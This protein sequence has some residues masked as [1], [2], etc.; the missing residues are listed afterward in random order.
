MI[1]NNIFTKTGDD[2][3]RESVEITNCSDD[4]KLT[5]EPEF[6][7]LDDSTDIF[8]SIRNRY[9][10]RVHSATDPPIKDTSVV[11]Q[12]LFRL[13]SAPETKMDLKDILND[14]LTCVVENVTLDE[15]N[16][17]DC[18][19]SNLGSSSDNNEDYQSRI[20]AEVVLPPFVNKE[21]KRQDAL[22]VGPEK[23]S[24]QD[25]LDISNSDESFEETNDM[26]NEI[27]F[28]SKS[29]S[30]DVITARDR[31]IFSTSPSGMYNGKPKS[32]SLENLYKT[33]EYKEI[34]K[35]ATSIEFCNLNNNYSEMSLYTEGS[36]SVFLSPVKKQF[37]KVDDF[38]RS[39]IVPINTDRRDSVI[40]SDTP[41]HNVIRT[42]SSFELDLGIN[43][44]VVK[45]EAILPMAYPDDIKPLPRMPYI[46]PVKEIQD[47]ISTEE[48]VKDIKKSNEEKL[49]FKSALNRIMGSNK[50]GSN[51][52]R[53]SSSPSLKLNDTDSNIASLN[54]YA[55]V[56]KNMNTIENNESQTAFSRFHI[57]RHSSPKLMKVKQPET[58]SEDVKNSPETISESNSA[59]L[60]GLNR[61]DRTSVIQF[62]ETQS[63]NGLVKSFNEAK[64]VDVNEK[65]LLRSFKQE[66]EVNK[67]EI[68]N[69]LHTIFTCM[70][71]VNVNNQKRSS[72]NSHNENRCSETPKEN[73]YLLDDEIITLDSPNY[74]KQTLQTSGA[75]IFDEVK[76]KNV[77]E[78]AQKSS[79]NLV[80]STPTNTK[81][82]DSEILT[83]E[84][85]DASEVHRQSKPEVCNVKNTKQNSESQESENTPVEHLHLQIVRDKATK[86]ATSMNT[87]T[88]EDST[89]LV[90]VTISKYTEKSEDD[91][92]DNSKV[93]ETTHAETFENN[94]KVI[95]DDTISKCS[96][97]STNPFLS[98]NDLSSQSTK[99]ATEAPFDVSYHLKINTV[100]DLVCQD[101]PRVAISKPSHQII[102]TTP[103]VQ[104]IRNFL[105]IQIINGN[106]F[107][108]MDRT[109]SPII[110]SPVLIQPIFF[111]PN[112]TVLDLD[113]KPENNKA[114]IYYDDIAQVKSSE[115]TSPKV[116]DLPK[117][118]ERQTK[119]QYQKNVKGK[120]LPFLSWKA[121]DSNESP[122]PGPKSPPSRISPR[123]LDSPKQ[124]V[125]KLTKTPEFLI[126]NHYYQPMEKVPFVIN[127]TQRFTKPKVLQTQVKE[128]KP[129]TNPFLTVNQPRKDSEEN[130]YEEIGQPIPIFQKAGNNIADDEKISNKCQSA[131]DDFSS[132]TR[133]E[134]LKVP[135]RP[136]RPKKEEKRVPKIEI[137]DATNVIKE[138]AS[139]TKSVISLSRSPSAKDAEKKHSG[140][141]GAIVHNL[142]K[143]SPQERLRK[144]S[145]QGQ[146]A[147]LTDV[148]TGSLPRDRKPYWKTLEHKRL[149]HPIRSLNDPPPPRPL[150]KLPMDV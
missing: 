30:F 48:N 119:G 140:P 75:S 92:V 29:E 141:V 50:N 1:S 70:E 66:S 78:A 7:M 10:S 28:L 82:K 93:S 123:P 115:N 33:D 11:D 105:P 23:S 41:V 84:N 16:D 110:I 12:T 19:R 149:S 47:T 13:N 88:S 139:M 142:E 83:S 131:R 85:I 129:S 58:I 61:G 90:D 53:R 132:V 91:K 9:L 109:P 144:L 135:R 8:K 27:K 118:D 63:D 34:L 145:L 57:G 36:D 60:T 121:F 137:E 49:T 31:T 67:P 2:N 73:T 14:T 79:D 98:T 26:K 20:L 72:I 128:V 122:K 102:A 111:K 138:M 45:A 150:R 86:V 112:S 54:K 99:P 101:V 134:I 125:L 143:N 136:R 103:K 116:L 104:G 113:R 25:A 95:S 17:D 32:F 117:I 24:R 107:N 96:N 65:P 74:H 80:T 148:N 6:E 133:E 77:L 62:K 89:K 64:V 5:K 147:P 59:K 35:E 43:L 68:T 55:K 130:Y 106:Y 127:T 40:H 44:P 42:P 120:S 94:L 51:K 81:E 87:E 71:A 56:N 146:N 69:H 3:M 18:N 76:D 21:L 100:N 15:T 22:D 114:K 108:Q 46:E 126:D 52:D 39:M 38:G 37:D 97:A 4:E 124:K